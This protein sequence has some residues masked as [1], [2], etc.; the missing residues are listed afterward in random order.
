VIDTETGGLPDKLKKEALTEVALTELAIVV[1][2]SITLKVVDKGSWLIKP[3]KEGLIYDPYAAKASGIDKKMCEEQGI[4]FEQAFKEF[5]ELIKRNLKAA[6]VKKGYL[7]G[8][9][10]IEFDLDF[11]LNMFDYFH[12]DA[13]E[14]FNTNVKDT[15]V[16][17][18]DKWPD[19]RKQNLQ[20]ISE[21]LNIPYVEAHRALP[22]AEMTAKVF[23]EFMKLLRGETVK[24]EQ[25]KQKEE[26][27]QPKRAKFE[28]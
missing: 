28:L 18:R 4:D 24:V 20:A 27:V 26:D 2:D 16:I 21:R 5:M 3:Y 25:P 11:I 13:S 1:L 14:Y 6:K 9:K 22:D 7:V 15:M 10:F 8:Q 19:E 23:V 17:S 12:F